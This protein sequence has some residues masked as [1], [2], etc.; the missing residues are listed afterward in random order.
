MDSKSFW[1]ECIPDWKSQFRR[2][3]PFVLVAVLTVATAATA[4]GAQSGQQNTNV[5]DN[6]TQLQTQQQDLQE[7]LTQTKDLLD[8]LRA[9]ENDTLLLLQQTQTEKDAVDDK[10]EE[11]KNALENVENQERQKWI[12]PIQY[13][14]CSSYYG[15]RTHPVNGVAAFHSGV[16]LAADLGT[17]IVAARSGT[18]TVAEYIEND[19]G[20][21]VLIDH[22]DGFESAYMHMDKFI[23][24]EGQ[25]VLAGQIIGYCGSSG[26]AD[27]NHLHFEIRNEKRTVNPADYIDLY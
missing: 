12:L 11:L 27:G 26:I 13:K 14:R 21:W 15:N 7:A 2:G 5:A 16:D 19:A 1:H 8:R 18:V 10:I 22:L 6:Q 3:L 23:V 4:L 17:P 20:Y 25:F 24:T 9:L